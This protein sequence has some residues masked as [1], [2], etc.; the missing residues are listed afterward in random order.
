MLGRGAGNTQCPQAR[1][2]AAPGAAR[3]R[4][5]GGLSLPCTRPSAR[6]ESLLQNPC[7]AT[8]TLCKSLL[9]FFLPNRGNISQGF[10]WMPCTKCWKGLTG[11]DKKLPLLNQHLLQSGA[12]LV[13]QEEF[14]W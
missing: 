9:R 2:D 10:L 14:A 12:V 7:S 1:R 6:A 13:G 11:R 5:F 4:E 3:S 8:H